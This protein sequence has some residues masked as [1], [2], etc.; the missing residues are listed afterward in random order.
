MP[1]DEDYAIRHAKAKVR[2]KVLDARRA[3]PPE[4]LAERD[5]AR[6]QRISRR[7]QALQPRCVAL[8][9]SRDEEPGTLDLL[10][11]LAEAGVEVLLPVLKTLAPPTVQAKGGGV[12]AWA[13]WHGEEL[14]K[15]VLGIPQPTSAPETPEIL[16]L[17]D[18]IVLPGIAGTTDGARLGLGGGW[19]D[20]AL[21]FARPHT[22]RWLL[23][24]DS[25]VMTEVPIEPHDLKVTHII[26]ESRWIDCI[27]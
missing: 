14:G 1:V 20:R 25:E 7:L 26:T 4:T 21:T 15:P 16:R 19:Y 24:N 27:Q 12:P 11:D 5:V 3:L 18:V 13:R 6:Y 8:Y 22:P 2:A 23:L 10:W 9:V 17:A